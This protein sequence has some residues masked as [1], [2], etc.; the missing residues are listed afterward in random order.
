MGSPTIGSHSKKIIVEMNNFKGK[1]TSYKRG[2]EI[3]AGFNS[4]KINVKYVNGGEG[5][6]Y[7]SDDDIYNS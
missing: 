7:F 6:E 3:F 4:I 5:F 1:V 2:I